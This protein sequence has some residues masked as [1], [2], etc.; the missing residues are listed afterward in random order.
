MISSKTIFSNGTFQLDVRIDE[1][2]AEEDFHLAIKDYELYEYQPDSSADSDPYIRIEKENIEWIANETETAATMLCKFPKTTKND[3]QNR[4]VK[5]VVK[6]LPDVTT[7][8][9]RQIHI[10]KPCC[11]ETDGEYYIFEGYDAD[12]TKYEHDILDS[13]KLQ[14]NDCEVPRDLLNKL[15]KL[16]AVR[17]AVESK[18]HYMEMMFSKLMCNSKYNRLVNTFSRGCNCN[19]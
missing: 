5:W 10:E 6:I 18:S 9:G 15:L 16:F 8:D 2:Y 14:C 4:L 13:I 19:G 3:V 1:S 17:A 11:A 7:E 12:L